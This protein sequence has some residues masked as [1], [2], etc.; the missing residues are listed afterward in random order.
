[1]R[2]RVKLTVDGREVEVDPG[3]TVLAAARRVGVE[4]PTLCYMEGTKPLET[5]GVC[6]VEVAFGTGNARLVPACAT[7]VAE[8]M[9]VRT[10]TERVVRTRRGALELM[11]S[12]HLGD[13]VAPCESGCPAHIDIPGMLAAVAAGD[14]GRAMAAMSESVAFPGVLGR[15]CPAPCELVCRRRELDRTI[16]IRAMKRYVADRAQAGGMPKAGPSSG[17]RVAI[18]G[19]GIAGLSAA[20]FLLLE[21][22]AVT[23]F[24]KAD[25]AGGG[26]RLVPAFRLPTTVLDGEIENVM[27]L[28]VELK[29]GRTLGHDLSL[30]E[31]LVAHDAVLLATGARR[32]RPESGARS[33][34]DLLEACAAGERPEAPASALVAGAD[35]AAVDACRT[36]V[37]LGVERVVLLPESRPGPLAKEGLAQA[38]SEGVEVFPPGEVVSSESADGARLRV[39]FGGGDGER[40]VEVDAFY[41]APKPEADAE[42]LRSLGEAGR[43]DSKAVSTARESVFAAGGVTRPQGLAVHSAAAG[44]K[45]AREID[46]FLRGEPAPREPVRVRMGKLSDETKAALFAGFGGETRGEVRSLASA[47]ARQSFDETELGLDEDAARLEARSCLRCDCAKK[48]ACRLRDLATEHG[49]A[50]GHYAGEHPAF[51]RDSSH[52][53]VIYE[54]GK[55]VKCGRCAAIAERAGEPV[56]IAFLGRGAA[57]RVGVPLGQVLGLTLKDGLR[58]VALDVA[59]QCPT[60]AL[61]LASR[62]D[63]Q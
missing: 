34:V 58:E 29:T 4:V 63:R 46:A 50:P 14:L 49:A 57:V 11:L 52:P 59:R 24:E 32:P 26:L 5:C 21:G 27:R 2:S 55:C 7:R 19:A 60:G 38:R 18:V 6:M 33:A 8:G 43:M 40:S 17:K 28:G 16:S 12:D 22:H 31:L 53:D 36:L 10:D 37:R 30:D 25:R 23:V 9:S 13:C 61:Y 42:F 3:E 44:R 15:V 51:A 35:R 41:R 62:D 48:D 1:M 54:P 20:H 47:E 45:A 56:G 39:V